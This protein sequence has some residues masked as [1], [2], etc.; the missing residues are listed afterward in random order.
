MNIPS[1]IALIFPRTQNCGGAL[2]VAAH[3]IDV[4]QDHTDLTVMTLD[5]CKPKIWNRAF[6]TRLSVQE[7]EWISFEESYPTL[8]KLLS[9][10]NMSTVDQYVLSAWARHS[11]KSETIPLSVHNEMAFSQ[12]GMQYIHFPMLMVGR[13]DLAKLVGQSGTRLKEIVGYAC[14]LLSGVKMQ[15]L[16]RNHTA[17]NSKWTCN[18]FR[19]YYGEKLTPQCLYPPCV[20]SGVES[21]ESWLNREHGVV[22][23]GRLVPHKHIEDGLRIVQGMRARGHDIHLHL[24]SGGG[25]EQYRLELLKAFGDARWLHWE[26]GISREELTKLVQTH[27]Y[28]I[29]CN[30]NEH[31]GMV[32]AEMSGSGCIVLGHNSGGTCEILSLDEQRYESI[33]TAIDQFE[34]IHTSN[35]MQKK[36][37][38]FNREHS[39]K[40]SLKRFEEQL[41]KWISSFSYQR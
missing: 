40:F 10:L 13:R 1:K 21:H 27:R 15:H 17:C 38:D 16:A 3:I 31:F 36:I 20:M 14:R 22:M 35:Q 23:I 28:G 6:G 41:L 2:A 25:D 33:T 19:E 32:T 29:H 9:L 24:V 37:L 12:R 7:I 18:V 30:R 4:L 39:R 8:G 11:L 26:T 5:H 34:E